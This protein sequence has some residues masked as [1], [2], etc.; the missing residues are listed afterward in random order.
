M[1]DET[2]QVTLAALMQE[3][4]HQAVHEKDPPTECPGREKEKEGPRLRIQEKV[5]KAGVGGREASACAAEAKKRHNT[6]THTHTHTPNRAGGSRE[7]HVLC[8]RCY[9]YDGGVVL[10]RRCKRLGDPWHDFPRYI[11]RIAYYRGSPAN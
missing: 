2:K 4:L 11:A 10:T 9:G 6:H 3:S 5:T 8:M 7:D 1:G